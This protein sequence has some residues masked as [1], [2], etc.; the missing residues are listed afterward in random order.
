MQNRVNLTEERIKALRPNQDGE[1]V[2]WDTE[3]RGFGVRCW[4]SG[5]KL[6][7][8]LYRANGGGRKAPQRR[9]TLGEVGSV[10][11]ADART[12]ARK[13]VGQ[14]AGGLDPQ[15]QRKEALRRD[16][17]RLDRAIDA[18]EKH[19]QGRH[20]VNTVHI[21]SLL[22]RELLGPL[23]KVDVQTIDRQSVADQITKLEERKKPGA[24]QDLRSKSATF[25]NWC[26]NRGLLQANPL[27]GWRRDRTTRAQFTC[28]KGRA[29]P[30][31]ELKLIWRGCSAVS[32]PYGDYV[33]ILLLLGQRR[34]ETA[35]MKRAD[36]DFAKSVWTI[37]GTQTKNGREHRVPLPSFALAILQRQ[38]KWAGCDYVFAGAGGNAMTGWSKRQPDLVKKCGVKFNLHDCRRTFR[39]GLTAVGTEEE[40]AELM[41]NHTRE[42]LLETY[43]R[44]PRWKERVEAAQKWAQYIAR[45]VEGVAVKELAAQEMV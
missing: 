32:A 2:L 44:E 29:I 40:V 30:E 42:E 39:S 1:V 16:A 36:V 28:R 6:F 15:N 18:Y 31:A 12:A 14:I 17:A 38:K 27:G 4:P 13:Y 22:R 24:A 23:G 45:I 35:L 26:V 3:V 10:R 25:L 41:L 5:R 33:R 8:L 9:M 19:L 7:I 21:I 37:P 43:D 20:V 34:K 11:L